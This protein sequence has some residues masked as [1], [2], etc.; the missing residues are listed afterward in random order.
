[1]KR[2]FFYNNLKI[3]KHNNTY[4]NIKH[5]NKKNRSYQSKETN[6]EG[7]IGR[8]SGN[9][10]QKR[11]MANLSCKPAITRLLLDLP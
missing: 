5:I 6:C 11:D 2:S 3:H 4:I 8:G 1:M 7:R 9:P 10:F